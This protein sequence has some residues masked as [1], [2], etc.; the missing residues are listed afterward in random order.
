M[1]NKEKKSAYYEVYT[2]A[3][4]DSN[5]DGIGD[6][7]G[8]KSKLSMINQIG[9]N[10]ILIADLFDKNT[11]DFTKIKDFLGKS[12]D[13]KDLSKKAKEF[14]M[15]IIIDF[16]GESLYENLDKIKTDFIE[17]IKY[18]KDKA[19]KGIRITGADFLLKKGLGEDLKKIKDFCDGENLLFILGLQNKDYGKGITDFAYIENINSYIKRNAYKDFYEILDSLQKDMENGD[20][21]YGLNFTNLSYPR[22][23]DKVLDEEEE[24]VSL[25]KAFYIMLFSLKTI[26]FVFQGEEIQAKSEYNIDIEKINDEDIKKTYKSLKDD[27]LNHDEAIKKIKKTTNFSTKTPLRWDESSLG[28]FSDLENYYGILVNKNNS[29]KQEL[30]DID[31]FLY[32]LN[33][34]IMKRKINSAYGLWSYE[35]ISLDESAYIYKRSYKDDDYIVLVNLSDDFYLVDEDISKEIEDGE[36]L[37]NNKK[38]FEPEVLDIYQALVIKLKK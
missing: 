6:I 23:V 9:F 4:K 19:V 29:F 20:I 7:R 13:I 30:K 31:S 26:P 24:S 25:I 28:G 3:F 11:K 36:V 35:K 17:I 16:D 1:E 21:N 10:Y 5:K 8:L 38:D 2:K 32:Y 12:E 22:L 33:E 27:G 14:R 37:I 15:K 18:W 34:L